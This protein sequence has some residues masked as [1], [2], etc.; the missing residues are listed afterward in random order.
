M[1]TIRDLYRVRQGLCRGFAISSTTVTGDD[2]DR[3]M[4]SKPGLGRRGLA[5]RQQRD[6]P[7]PFE[8]ADDAGVSVIA[9][10]G[11]IIN[12]HR[13]HQPFCE[14]CRRSTA[15]RQAEV[16][17]DGVQPRRASRR[18]SQYPLG[19]ALSEDL[20]PAQDGIA[21]EAASDQQEL[22]DPPRKRQIGHASSRPAMHAPVNRSA[23][24]TQTNV[25]GCPDHND[26]LIVFV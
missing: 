6:Y 19:E 24:W 5:I 15:K 23:R 11:P 22:H 21:A 18:W 20:A 17:N 16:M 3:G 1:P 13:Q 12:A 10:P 25:S 9:P 8:V 7:A 26:G 4:S 2:R 14:A